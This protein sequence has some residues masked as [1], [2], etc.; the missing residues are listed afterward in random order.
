MKHQIVSRWGSD[1]VLFE[2]DV[3]DG[4]ESGLRYALEKATSSDANLMGANLTGAYLTR[5]NLMGAN[6]TGANLTGADLTGADFTR[7]RWQDITI[8]KPPIQ[9]FGLYWPVTILD[10]HM[11]IGCELHSLAEWAE[12]DDARI[13]RM[14]GRNALRF[15]RAH[16]DA[17]LALAKSA[18]REA[19][20]AGLEP[21]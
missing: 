19:E 3:P 9:L 4:I 11:Q 17:L 12:F 15:W 2:C 16:K 14:D 18:G 8:S 1:K 6:L 13:A 21:A 10:S 20:V 7:A 5:A